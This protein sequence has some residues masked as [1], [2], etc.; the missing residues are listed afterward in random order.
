MVNYYTIN[1]KK[2]RKNRIPPGKGY[3][4]LNKAPVYINALQF[5][6]EKNLSEMDKEETK[7]FI[8]KVLE[9]NVEKHRKYSYNKKE[10]IYLVKNYKPKKPVYEGEIMMPDRVVE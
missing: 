9:K 5:K 8:E 4:N 3:E 1:V 10:E 6:T 7:V 2:E